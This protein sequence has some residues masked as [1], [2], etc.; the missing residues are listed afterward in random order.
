MEH[1]SLNGLDV[2]SLGDKDAE[3]VEN[4]LDQLEIVATA[5]EWDEI[6]SPT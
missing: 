4:W 2:H 3:T 5:F 6:D 1:S